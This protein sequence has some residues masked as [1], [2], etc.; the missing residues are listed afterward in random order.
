MPTLDR[1]GMAPRNAA[2]VLTLI[3]L[4]S[5]LHAGVGVA[6]TPNLTVNNGVLTYRADPGVANDLSITANITDTRFTVTDSAGLAAG[7]GCQ[8]IDPTTGKC[9]VSVASISVM[10]GDLA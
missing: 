7:A 9:S 1:L 6:A 3:T 10:T 8:Q 5:F 2:S 4:V